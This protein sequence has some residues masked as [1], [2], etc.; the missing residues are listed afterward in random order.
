MSGHLLQG[1]QGPAFL[2]EAEADG[3]QEVPEFV[4]LPL[5]VVDVSRPLVVNGDEVIR[6]VTGDSPGV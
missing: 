1:V 4:G 5:T 3:F 2:A 6:R